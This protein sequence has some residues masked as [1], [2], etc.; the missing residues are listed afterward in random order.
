[1]SRWW[2]AARPDQDSAWPSQDPGWL[3]RLAARDFAPTAPQLHRA[4]TR[5]LAAFR[6]A[7]RA[8]DLAL[9]SSPATKGP[10]HLALA[11]ARIGRSARLAFVVALVVVVAG[12]GGTA[13]SGPGAP[14][15]AM[16]LAVERTMLPAPGQPA[17]LGAELAL[18]DRRLADAAA[19]LRREDTRAASAALGAVAGDVAG[20]VPDAVL[21]SSRRAVLARL[22]D[23]AAAVQ[24][25]GVALTG[26]GAVTGGAVQGALDA[27]R[28]AREKLASVTDRDPAADSPRGADHPGA[29]GTPPDAQS[30]T[31]VSPAG[32]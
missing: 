29:S 5:A 11:D 20:I 10:G 2:S 25:L 1:M 4:E 8:T 17:R 14:L 9:T 26:G 18:V 7:R 28:S 23:D 27:L 15:Y 13:A 21:D 6:A 32:R 3:R 31:G 16:R 22:D 30:R 12:A 19:A 24:R